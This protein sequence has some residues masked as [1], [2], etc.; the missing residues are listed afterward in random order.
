VAGALGAVLGG[1]GGGG[2]RATGG[3]FF[4]QPDTSTVMRSAAPPSVRVNLSQLMSIVLSRP[5]L[6][7]IVTSSV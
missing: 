7:L 3:C 1:G 6:R 4:A 5:P 2:S